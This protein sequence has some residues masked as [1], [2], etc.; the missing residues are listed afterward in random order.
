MNKEIKEVSA[1]NLSEND[2]NQLASEKIENV[3]KIHSMYGM[4]YLSREAALNMVTYKKWAES[5][6]LT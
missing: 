2:N 1:E 4:F 5:L 3:D 6:R